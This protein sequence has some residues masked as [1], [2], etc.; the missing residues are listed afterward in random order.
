MHFCTYFLEM[1]YDHFGG[2]FWRPGCFNTDISLERVC[3]IKNTCIYRTTN[4]THI[5]FYARDLGAGEFLTIKTWAPCNEK[6]NP[7]RGDF[8]FHVSLDDGRG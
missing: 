7:R 2:A 5:D 8:K 3:K 1:F 4:Y 6:Q